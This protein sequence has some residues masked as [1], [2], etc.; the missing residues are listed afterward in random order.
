MLLL[1]HSDEHDFEVRQTNTGTLLFIN[2]GNRLCNGTLRNRAEQD[3]KEDHPHDARL[4]N[5][6]FEFDVEPVAQAVMRRSIMFI[7][8]AVCGHAE[9]PWIR[10]GWWGADD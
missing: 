4:P 6:G 1:V 3:G 5:F 8:K 2:F 7:Q 10:F 9:G